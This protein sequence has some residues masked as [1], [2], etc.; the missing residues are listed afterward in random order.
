MKFGKINLVV[1]AMGI[2]LASIGGMVLGA[3]YS[4]FFK[5]GY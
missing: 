2:L 1:G 3:T 5:E 4:G